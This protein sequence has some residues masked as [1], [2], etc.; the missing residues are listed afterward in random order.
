MRM[1]AYDETY[2]DDAMCNLGEMLDYA[3]NVC[4]YDIDVFF[5]YFIISGVGTQFEK[6]NPKYVTGMSGTELAWDV[7]RKVTGSCEYKE[8]NESIDRSREYWTGWVMAYY[9]WLRNMTF[10]ELF[11]RGLTPAKVRRDY[12][13][14]EAD[15]T[16][17]VDMADRAIEFE[18]YN[19]GNRLK[20]MRLYWGYTQ[21]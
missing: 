21:K 9:Q 13:L 1:N 15:I 14:H 2:L 19:V 7:I 16:K 4:G 6:G 12:I 5:R 10:S 18:R 3:V 11:E 17:F 8:P 20:R